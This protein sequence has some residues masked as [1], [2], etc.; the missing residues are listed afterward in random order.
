MTLETEN[1]SEQELRIYC[2]EC[3]QKLDVSHLT[4]FEKIPCPACSA[5]IIVPE[6]FDSYLLEERCGDGGVAVVYRALD[7]TLDR[8]VAIKISSINDSTLEFSEIFLHEG[9]VAASLNHPG[10]V[11]IYSC[12][13]FNGRCFIVMQYMPRGTLENVIKDKWELKISQ[14]LQWMLDVTEALKFA[15]DSGIVHHD[16]KPANILVDFDNNV[17]IGDFGLAYALN[18][19]KSEHLQA[20]LSTFG[21]PDYVSPEK[22]TDGY[23]ST[24]GDIFSLGVTFYELITGVKP[25]KK[26]REDEDILEVRESEPVIPPSSLR[27]EASNNLSK[28]IMSMLEKEPSKRP[29]YNDI[30]SKLKVLRKKY[31]KHEDKMLYRFVA[32][33]L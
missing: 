5:E 30:L 14:I 13:E 6:W 3:Q 16:I 29:N 2:H 25:F 4:P 23:E 33:Y 7:L 12:G 11:P 15:L 17:K 24:K 10:I 21:S 22:L 8:E 32:K 31:N 28:L 19:I 1:I 9:R 26:A 18:D 27:F 20:E